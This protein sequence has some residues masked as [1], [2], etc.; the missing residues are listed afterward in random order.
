MK[1]S[2]R[3]AQKEIDLIAKLKMTSGKFYLNIKVNA[4]DGLDFINKSDKIIDSLT[5]PIGFNKDHNSIY[6]K[7]VEIIISTSKI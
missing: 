3:N 5:A 2:I 1:T 7:D 4:K 6:N